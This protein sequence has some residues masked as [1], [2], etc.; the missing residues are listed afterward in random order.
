MKDMRYCGK[1]CVGSHTGTS[2]RLAQ[3]YM[4]LTVYLRIA[5]RMY[6]SSS[7]RKCKYNIRFLKSQHSLEIVPVGLD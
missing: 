5:T 1:V 3:C 2:F 4:S 7:P 6:A